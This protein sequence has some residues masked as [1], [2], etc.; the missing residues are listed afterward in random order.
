MKS[1]SLAAI[2]AN[3]QLLISQHR[4]IESL[5]DAHARFDETSRWLLENF[6]DQTVVCEGFV[7]KIGH[8]ATEA[9]RDSCR[10][11]MPLPDTITVT[12]VTIEL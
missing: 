6:P 10:H 11:W 8:K 9:E 12:P 4:R 3:L 1:T 2:R 5:R 7:V